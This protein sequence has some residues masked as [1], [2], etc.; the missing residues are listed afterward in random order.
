VS[1]Q[2]KARCLAAG[3]NGIVTK[4]VSPARLYGAL[5]SYLKPEAT[6]ERADTVAAD[7]DPWAGDPSIIDLSV[8]AKN[9]PNNP[10]KIRKF[11]FRFLETARQSIDEADAA[12]AQENLPLL[13]ALGHKSKSSARAAGAMGFADLWQALEQTKDSGGLAQSRE[14]IAGLRPLLA[15]IEQHL[16]AVFLRED[17]V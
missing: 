8:L 4:P 5:I 11:A 1:E 14:I 13:A 15:Q 2:D 17:A 6:R 10:E 16:D 3:M 7:S 12:L 9:F